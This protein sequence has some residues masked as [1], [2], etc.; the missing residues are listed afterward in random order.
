MEIE[1]NRE[2]LELLYKSYGFEINKEYKDIV[3]FIYKKS[4]YYGV[5]IVPVK[6]LDSKIKETTINS[7]RKKYSEIGYAI[8]LKEVQTNEDAEIELYKSFF[9]Y[10]STRSRLKRKYDDFKKKQT[11]SLFGYEYTYIE[12]PYEINSEEE[13]DKGLIE[14]LGE[15]LN[16]NTPQ[17]I[18]LE[19]AAG[20]GKTCSAYEVLKYYTDKI[21]NTTPIF[22]ELSRNRGANIFRYILLDEID[23]EYPTLGSE[24][25]IKEIK[26]GRIPLIIDGFDEL[27]DKVSIDKDASKT[28]DEIESMLDTI[29]NLLD[30]KTKVLLTTRKTA[31]FTGLE[32]DRWLN[33]WNSKFEIT[34]ISIKEPKIKDWLGE[35]KYG[36]INE[37]HVPIHYI[38]NPVIL[39]FLK[40]LP[41]EEFLLQINNPD[42]LVQQYF[43][44]MLEREKERQNLIITV[45]KQLEIFRNVA[46]MLVAF[47]ITVESKDFIKDI[48]LE[49]NSRLLEYTRSL[50]GGTE[51]PSMENLV[52]SLA[53]HAL[54]DRKGRDENQ[55]G[56]INDF[57]FGVFIGDVLC[58]T[59]DANIDELFSAYM[60]ELAASA[61][62]VQ[63]KNKK[64]EL[65][66]KIQNVLSKF[67]SISVFNFD[68]YLQT[69]IRHDFNE[70]TVY[71]FT[72][73]EITFNTNSI[74]NSVFINC[75]FK[76]CH[77]DLTTFKGVSF[78]NCTFIDS[79]ALND[80]YFD[81]SNDVSIIKGTYRGTH[82]YRNDFQTE[83]TIAQDI[84]EIEK[85]ILK[86]LWTIS[87]TKSHHIVKLLHSC[88]NYS[89]KKIL[90]A[91]ENLE[92][93]EFIEI[94][95]HHI[96]LEINKLT[97]IKQI[98]GM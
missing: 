89:Q 95:G 59:P 47:D 16:K 41:F 31:I 50:Y 83:A 21:E 67:Q 84:N 23:I 61:Y 91:L 70:V 10:N 71:D 40:N 8:N 77:F 35:D 76:K 19:A 2:N 97:I 98:I 53:T 14:T 39:T 20:Y 72:F 55:I 5:D 87:H 49:E 93:K 11:T 54:L 81:D 3:V 60:I 18:I 17:L 6:D 13:L 88:K 22:T 33:K 29:G 62:R 78:V 46:K 24:L 12:S 1:I 56:F 69:S 64:I 73:Y 79:D 52:D 45:D 96:N 94:R 58:D 57:I 75:L 80:Y 74:S 86:E 85:E 36:A 51:K 43:K 63:S 66:Q 25:V 32:F 37:K 34:R 26:N 28:F 27:L 42:L 38:A 7:I 30:K 92:L 48:I 9:A 68:I 15:I 65:W 44:K 90:N 4:R 82:L